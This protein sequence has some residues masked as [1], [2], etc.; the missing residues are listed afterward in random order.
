MPVK[1]KEYNSLLTRFIEEQ[2]KSQALEEE[3]KKLMVKLLWEKEKHVLVSPCN[4][5]FE[6]MELQ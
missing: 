3:N 4:E 6:N 5:S 1:Q 2:N